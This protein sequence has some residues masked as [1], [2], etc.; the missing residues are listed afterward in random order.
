MG[1]GIEDL[2]K[3]FEDSG[4]EEGLGEEKVEEVDGQDRGF[5]LVSRGRGPLRERYRPQKLEE[6]AP[7][8][9]VKQLRNFIDNPNASKVFLFEGITGTGKTTCARIIA[10][11]S[12]CLAD[13]TLDKPCLE[14]S[15]CE[16]FEHNF[17]ITEINA[18]NQRKIDDVRKLV[19]LMR[20]RPGLG[21]C[22]KKVYILDEVHQYTP[23]A[24]Q[25]L[26][27]QLEDPAPYLLVFL[28]TTDAHT[29]NK[30]LIDRASMVSFTRLSGGVGAS[31]VSQVCDREGLTPSDEIKESFYKNSK[32]SIR[33]L[34]NNIQA[35][36]EG[37]YQID[38]PEDEESAD[39]ARIATAILKSDFPSLVVCLR[40]QLLRKEPKIMMSK[41]TS[42]FRGILLAVHGDNTPKNDFDRALKVAN[43]LARL[44]GP[45]EG[46]HPTD[47]Y[48]ALVSRCMRAL[49][50]MKSS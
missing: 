31:I 27:T 33:R 4:L 37:G 41:L 49:N 28:C 43:V 6:I 15:S 12:V 46:A 1:E 5:S 22:K 47:N 17:E 29:M 50:V 26:L 23:E 21:G 39:I 10:K 18:A 32:G 9:S 30:A 8:C 3:I 34:L 36:A 48:N 19:E 42:Y 44:V 45:L 40:G 2:H 35:Y 11:A 16:D 7:T 24:Q 25:V 20:Y 14:C 38:A 13:N